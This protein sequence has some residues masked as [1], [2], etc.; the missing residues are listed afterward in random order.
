[1]IGFNKNEQAGK[2]TLLLM[3]NDAKQTYARYFRFNRSILYIHKS[4]NRNKSLGSY[5]LKANQVLEGVKN[6]ETI[7]N[8]IFYNLAIGNIHLGNLEEAVQNIFILWKS[9]LS[10]NLLMNLILVFIFY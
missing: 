6:A 4:A 9:C 5:Y 10:I 3:D 2:F 1:M 8:N 7:K